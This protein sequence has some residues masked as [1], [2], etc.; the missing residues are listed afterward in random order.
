MWDDVSYY[1]GCLLVGRLC[2]GVSRFALWFGC[3][4]LKVMGIMVLMVYCTFW[5]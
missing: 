4:N 5:L 2:G 1:V 3:F